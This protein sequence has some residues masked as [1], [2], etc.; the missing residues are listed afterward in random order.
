MKLYIDGINMANHFFH[1]G[2]NPWRQ[3]LVMRETVKV[4]M[5]L[6]LESYNDVRVFI[7]AGYSRDETIETY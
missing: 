3:I 6:I 5:K 4:F 7:D 1:Q 2:T